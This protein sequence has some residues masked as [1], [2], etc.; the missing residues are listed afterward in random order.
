MNGMRLDLPA[1]TEL[2]KKEISVVHR[3]LLRMKRRFRLALL[4]A[5]RYELIQKDIENACAFSIG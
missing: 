5:A 2:V 4:F 3:S 1:V